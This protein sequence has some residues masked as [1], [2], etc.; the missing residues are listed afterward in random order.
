MFALFLA[1]A[2]T[3]GAAAVAIAAATSPKAAPGADRRAAIR[4]EIAKR[5]E[6]GVKRLQ[7]WVKQPAIAAENRGM[8]E[9]CDTMM[10]LAR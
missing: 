8:N 2:L 6:E 7:D 10:R 1:A 4:A 5:H 9:G 3:L